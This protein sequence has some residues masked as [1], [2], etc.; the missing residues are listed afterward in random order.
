LPV[1]EEVYQVCDIDCAG[2]VGVCVL[3]P[4]GGGTG[5]EIEPCE[6]GKVFE[7]DGIIGIE[8]GT[9]GEPAIGEYE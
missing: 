1:L 6:D 9:A 4:I 8:V 5:V 2:A 7:V 3:A